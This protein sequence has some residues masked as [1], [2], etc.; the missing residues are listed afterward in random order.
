M[1]QPQNRSE[2]VVRDKAGRIVKLRRWR[3]HCRAC[4][5]KLTTANSWRKPNGSWHTYCRPCNN[6]RSKEW[7][8]NHREQRADYDRFRH[9]GIPR[10]T[11]ARLVAEQ[12]GRCAICG[13]EHRLFVDHDHR[14]GKVRAAL[15][16]R[17]NVVVGALETDIAAKAMEYLNANQ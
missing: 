13:E 16:N 10:G 15:C 12:E 11:Y 1:V 2:A 7:M 14:T 8:R 9:R 4:G 3:F 17:C 5:V 6:E